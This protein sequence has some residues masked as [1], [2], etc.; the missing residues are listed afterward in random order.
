MLNKR[1]FLRRRSLGLTPKRS[2]VYAQNDNTER[3]ISRSTD[4]IK[5]KDNRTLL[6]RSPSDVMPLITNEPTFVKDF[7]KGYNGNL[8]DIYE[9][10]DS[11]A[12]SAGRRA[13][14]RKWLE[15]NGAQYFSLKILPT[16]HWVKLIDSGAFSTA[17]LIKSSEN[18]ALFVVKITKDT[19]KNTNPALREISLLKELSNPYVVK[20]YDNG[21][22]NKC[23]WSL[24]EYCNMGTVKKMGLP[25]VLSKRS[26]C[27][28]HIINGLDYLHSKGIAHRDIKSDNIFVHMHN[29]EL[30]F[31]L[32]D[33]N[34]ARNIESESVTPL[35]FCGSYYTMAPEI[36]NKQPYDVRCDMWSYL[37]LLLE[38]VNGN[39]NNPLCIATDSLIESINDLHDIE[40]DI[41]KK[42]HFID[43]ILRKTSKDI[44]ECIFPHINALFENDRKRSL[45]F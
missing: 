32:G 45:T 42:L 15:K 4:V 20:L 40:K 34:L 23:H 39:C 25:L 12:L 44:K 43:P 9:K 1:N 35:S 7:V 29:E 33:F 21:Y 2:S 8:L 24:I 11:M 19:S 31:K 26:L 28:Y 38:M 37:C 5:F 41:I 36:L 18:N 27:L 17:H 13:T 30:I 16:Y 3:R 14:I 6:Q 22:E 10:L